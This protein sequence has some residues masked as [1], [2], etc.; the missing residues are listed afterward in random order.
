[1]C[2][3]LTCR[4]QPQEPLYSHLPSSARRTASTYSATCFQCQSLPGG[5]QVGSHHSL[6][7]Y[8][9]SRAEGCHQSPPGDDEH[10]LLP[11]RSCGNSLPRDRSCNQSHQDIWDP[12]HSPSGDMGPQPHS[13]PG[14]MGPLP[15][16]ARR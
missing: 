11:I 2:A 8:A 14:D 10:Q 13:P 3:C 9:W 15:L 16:S 5:N 7:I 12:Y 6:I 1:M 4:W